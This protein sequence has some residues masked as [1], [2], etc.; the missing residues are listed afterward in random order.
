MNKLALV[1]ISLFVVV[2]NSSW[3]LR[4]PGNSSLGSWFNWF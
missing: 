2:R 3:R 1:A 4:S